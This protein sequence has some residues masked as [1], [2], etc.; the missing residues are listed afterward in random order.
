MKP[1][2]Y[3]YPSHLFAELIRDILLLRKRD[4]HQDAKVCI[5]NINPPIKV[6]GP[7]C[8]PQHGACVI[9][10]NHYHREGFHAEWLALSISA[11]VPVKVH[12]IMTGEFMYE[13]KWYQSVASYASRILLKRIASI[14][15][16]TNMPPMPPR[17]KDIQERAASV[18]AVL[19]YIRHAENPVIGLA[20]EGYDPEGPEGTLT[21]PAPGL[22]RFAVLLSNAGLRFCPVGTYESDGVFHIHFG[23]PYLLCVEDHLSPSEKDHQASQVIMK[24][25]ARLVPLHLRGE[26]A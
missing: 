5:E 17:V 20:P 2:D 13:G 12:W 21:K 3:S 24:N 22:G 18:R 23:E 15:D 8:I 6:L 4:F 11:L 19:E 14:Y 16:F 10:V 25:I 26:Y 7:E 1:P 9:T